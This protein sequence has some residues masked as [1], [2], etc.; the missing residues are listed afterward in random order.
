[1]VEVVTNI[2]CVTANIWHSN[3]A[4]VI[5]ITVIS[6]QSILGL[7]VNTWSH[8]QYLVSLPIPGLIVRTWSHCQYLVSLPIPGLIVSTWSHCQYLVSLSIPGLIVSTWSHCQYVVS[9]PIRGLIFQKLSLV[10]LYVNSFCHI[11]IRFW[12]YNVRLSILL[13]VAAQE[14]Q[15]DAACSWSSQTSWR[16][17][18][19]S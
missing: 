7:I 18:I 5:T 11:F 16:R 6:W 8:C 15:T 1:M 19:A 4:V 14:C 9:L 17:N 2:F 12:Y 10:L 3:K 13:V